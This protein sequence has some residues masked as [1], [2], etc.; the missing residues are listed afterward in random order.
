MPFTTITNFDSTTVTTSRGRG[1][2]WNSFLSLPEQE[3]H[4]SSVAASIALRSLPSSPALTLYGE[5]DDGRHLFSIGSFTTGKNG[6]D[7]LI[8]ILDAALEIVEESDVHSRNDESSVVDDP[9]SCHIC[10]N[11][12]HSDSIN[13]QRRLGEEFCQGKQRL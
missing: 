10:R 2:D 4:M 13:D 9:S 7:R 1:F 5:N 11:E 12:G 8:A 3:H 6:V